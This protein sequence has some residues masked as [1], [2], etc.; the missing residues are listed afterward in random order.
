MKMMMAKIL[1]KA[2]WSGK[3][4]GSSAGAFSRVSFIFALYTHLAL[5]SFAFFA[6]QM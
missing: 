6:R 4:N 2:E 3:W 5:L 1:L